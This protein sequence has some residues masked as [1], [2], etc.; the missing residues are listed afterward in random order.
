MGNGLPFL[1]RL[2]TSL[3]N[4]FR[5]E[6]G[7]NAPPEVQ[8]FVPQ[9]QTPPA[10]GR[11]IRGLLADQRLPVASV[12]S[13]RMQPVIGVARAINEFLPVQPIADFIRSQTLSRDDPNFVKRRREAIGKQIFS[14][15]PQ[16]SIQ[17]FLPQQLSPLDQLLLLLQLLMQEGGLQ[18][19]KSNNQIG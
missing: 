5:P 13:Q 2:Q 9:A 8:S 18:S 16:S 3:G 14:T 4:Y 19:A 7:Q 15:Q 17:E 1:Q 6:Q 11:T 10:I 12:I